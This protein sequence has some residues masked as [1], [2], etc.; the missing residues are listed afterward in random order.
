MVM[1]AEAEGMMVEEEEET[2]ERWQ[3]TDWGCCMLCTI[4]PRIACLMKCK[5]FNP[6]KRSKQ[7]VPIIEQYEGLETDM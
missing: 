5:H 2:S 4:L 3:E 6:F 7:E 1:E